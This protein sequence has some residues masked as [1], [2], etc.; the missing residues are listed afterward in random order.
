MATLARKVQNHANPLASAIS[1]GL[2]MSPSDVKPVIATLRH[3]AAKI[4]AT[5]IVARSENFIVLPVKGSDDEDTRRPL[6]KG[7]LESDPRLE[8]DKQHA[9]HD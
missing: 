1:T 9:G 3:I 8:S 7:S 2:A 4:A 6:A 5:I